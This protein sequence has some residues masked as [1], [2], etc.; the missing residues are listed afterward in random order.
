MQRNATGTLVGI[1]VRPNGWHRAS[2]TVPGL[3]WP[4]RLDTK[5]EQLTAAMFPLVNQQVAVVYDES[6]SEN[7]NPNSGRPYTERRLQSIVPA[8]AL[9]GQQPPSYGPPATTPAV[10]GQAG[11]IEPQ[12]SPSMVRRVTWL[13]AAHTAATLLQNLLL[14]PS[15]PEQV[16]NIAPTMLAIA[17]TIYARAIEVGISGTQRQQQQQQQFAPPPQPAPPV[18]EEQ[19]PPHTDDDIPF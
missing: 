8:S 2:I 12:G 10:R 17:D 9:T 6:E 13:S 5:L 19:P 14:P 7:I 1:E 4:L 3:D 18:Q 15:T 11:T 16:K